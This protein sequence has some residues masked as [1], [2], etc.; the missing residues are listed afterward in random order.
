[1][2]T[3]ANGAGHC[4]PIRPMYSGFLYSHAPKIKRKLAVKEINIFLSLRDELMWKIFM[5]IIFCVMFFYN[6]LFE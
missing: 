4:D 1:L 2:E 6:I 5:K 3:A